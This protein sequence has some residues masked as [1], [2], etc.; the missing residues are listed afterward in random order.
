MMPDAVPFR[1]I[2][3]TGSEVW[4]GSGP[5]ISLYRIGTISLY[6]DLTDRSIKNVIFQDCIYVSGF[7]NL[8]YLG[9][10]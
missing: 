9:Q 7:R 6:V 10:N 5:E 1:D 2:P 8:L 4:V 3:T